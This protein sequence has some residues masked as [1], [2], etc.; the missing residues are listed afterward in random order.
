MLPSLVD[1]RVACQTCPKPNY[2]S[3]L[4]LIKAENTGLDIATKNKR[5]IYAFM[6]NIVDKLMLQLS[7]I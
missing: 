5:K 3:G 2:H 1:L 6:K 4:A 7:Q